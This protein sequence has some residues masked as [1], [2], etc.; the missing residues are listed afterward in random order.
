M[1]KLLKWFFFLGVGIVFLFCC[2]LLLGF[3][4][5]PHIPGSS[6]LHITLDGALRE[7]PREEVWSLLP[8][9]E[10]PSLYTVT[11]SIRRAAKDPRIKGLLLNIKDPMIGFAQIQ[12]IEQSMRIFRKTGKWNMSYL[13][14]AGEMTN[15]N[16]AYALATCAD[17]VI[18]CPAGSINI[19]GLRA[20]IPFVKKTVEKLQME[21]NVQK[22]HEY[23]TAPNMFTH[24]KMTATQ[25][26]TLK[27]IVDNIQ[28]EFISHMAKRRHA[29]EF[30]AKEWLKNGPFLADEA[31][32][33]KMVDTLGY[34][35][36][37]HSAAAEAA[38]RPH[39]LVSLSD[40]L[41][42]RHSFAGPQVALIVGEGTIMRGDSSNS[43]VMGS[44][45]MVQAFQDARNALVS[46][47]VFRVNSPGGSYVASDIIRR[48]V[49]LTVQAGIPVIASMG[50]T[51]ASGGYFVALPATEIMAQ[52]TSITGSI[53]VFFVSLALR[54][55][56]EHWL[57]VTFDAYGATKNAGFF[58]SLDL[59]TQEQKT[60]TDAFLD[61]IYRD[62]VTKVNRSRNIS[63]NKAESLARGRAWSG[64][65]AKQNGL[66]D[67]LGGLGTAFVRLKQILGIPSEQEL[68]VLVF[69]KPKTFFEQMQELSTDLAGMRAMLA[70]SVR[71]KS[72]VENTHAAHLLK[73]PMQPQVE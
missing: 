62:F 1:R 43:D 28:K 41:M 56:L 54:K 5:G 63:Y 4:A 22:R 49:E 71:W 64:F 20:E 13:E 26:E 55:P 52:P 21:V 18:L 15:G 9:S 44:K 70:H 31:L 65:A 73:W 48:E 60:R 19:V 14:T 12:E 23:K 7:T 37:V 25:L 32:A 53:G 69:P 35:D 51:A 17:K 40:Y 16:A 59:P 67:E 42:E 11:H 27:E 10:S 36:S 2:L 58:S 34:W 29:S 6:I 61:Q 57:G 39:P 24:E 47:I 45:T 46:G 3:C 8:E 50:E 72:W 38:K 33:K 66:V 30:Q 68:T